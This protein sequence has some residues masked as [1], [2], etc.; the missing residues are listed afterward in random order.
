MPWCFLALW[1]RRC[2]LPGR[3]IHVVCTLLSVSASKYGIR[4][5]GY[6]KAQA[7]QLRHNSDPKHG[8]LCLLLRASAAGTASQYTE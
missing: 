4:Q 8:N 7:T 6:L 5:S 1:P 3:S 2:S